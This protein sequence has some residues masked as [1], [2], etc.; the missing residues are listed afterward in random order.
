MFVHF[1]DDDLEF[2]GRG[3]GLLRELYKEL[4]FA[5]RKTPFDEK[6]G[7]Q[8]AGFVPD[9][10]MPRDCSWMSDVF[11]TN[12]LLYMWEQVKNCSP[13][14]ANGGFEWGVTANLVLHRDADPHNELRFDDRF[15]RSG[16]GEDIDFCIKLQRLSG[17]MPLLPLRASL[18]HPWRDSFW[19]MSRRAFEWAYGDS[20]LN[21]IY[22]RTHVHRDVPNVPETAIALVF[23]AAAA[24]ALCGGDTL[25]ILRAVALF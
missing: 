21:S 8:A 2:G 18:V 17:G 7:F 20:N 15:P 13:R 24:I 25:K 12:G 6:G 23:L 14:K 3:L 10:C 11:H 1:V 19:R 9:T 22:R 16:G 5:I 4:S